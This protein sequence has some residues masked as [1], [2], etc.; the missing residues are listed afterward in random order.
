MEIIEPLPT[1]W[2]MLVEAIDGLPY[3]GWTG[4]SVFLIAHYIGDFLFQSQ[5]IATA[6]S[7]S[8]LS[9]SIHVAIYTATI[10]A[11]SFLVDFTSYQRSVLVIYSGLIHFI[12]DYTTSRVTIAAHKKGDMTMFWDTIGFDQFIHIYTLYVLYG[13]LISK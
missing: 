2:K 5:D 13:M 1:I 7:S 6:K 11:F 8:N 10:L 3:S 9:L 12:T 4:F